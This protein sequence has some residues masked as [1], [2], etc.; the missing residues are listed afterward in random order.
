RHLNYSLGN[1]YVMWML[2]R[3]LTGSN[4][5]QVMLF[6]LRNHQ[7]YAVVFSFLSTMYSLYEY[8]AQGIPYRDHTSE[9]MA[10][11]IIFL[12]WFLSIVT[13]IN[14]APREHTPAIMYLSTVIP[15]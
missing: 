2:F 11:L 15:D 7:S 5:K 3:H 4:A 12:F 10:D 6:R 13:I 9:L 1:L 8:A 14:A